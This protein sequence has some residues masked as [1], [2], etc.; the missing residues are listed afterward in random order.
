[1]NYSSLRWEASQ[2]DQKYLPVK[3]LELIFRNNILS[4][5]LAKCVRYE[6]CRGDFPP[7]SPKD[8]NNVLGI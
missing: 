5:I 2:F 7:E 1:M 3:F 6:S 4:S 8:L